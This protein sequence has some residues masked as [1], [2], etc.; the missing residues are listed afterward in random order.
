[1]LFELL[2]VALETPGDFARRLVVARFVRPGAARIEHLAGNLG[3]TLRDV[4]AEMGFA[5]HRRLAKSAV[6][7]GAHQG[8][9]MGDRHALADAVGTA[10]PAGIDEPALRLVTAD[11]L[12]K[13]PR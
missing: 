6:Q 8:A 5:P 10:R 4:E 12:A 7:R 1:M 3:A 11:A 9:G 2:E 13:H